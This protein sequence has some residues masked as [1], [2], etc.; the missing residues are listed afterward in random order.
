[1][2]RLRPAK[3]PNDTDRPVWS[4][5]VNAGAV[6]PVSRRGMM[7]SFRW[8]PRDSSPGCMVP[9]CVMV[10]V[11]TSPD[12]GV[13]RTWASR[14]DPPRPLSR[15]RSSRP[16]PVWPAPSTSWRS[17]P[18]PRRLRADRPNPPRPSSSKSLTRPRAT[19]AWSASARSRRA[20]PCCWG[21]PSFDVTAI[22][23]GLAI[24][25]V[26]KSVP[27]AADD[28]LPIRMLH[29][30]VLVSTEGEAGERQ[31]GGGLVIPATASIGKRLAWATVVAI[32]QHVRQIQVG[33][34]ILYDPEDRAEVELQSKGYVLLRERDIHAVAEP[35]VEADPTG[36]SL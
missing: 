21:W 34:R 8:M 3:S 19:Y 1:M 23:V 27:P 26:A 10:P 25:A 18:S 20:R 4:S 7:E 6:W 13:N 22:T 35:R 11:E 14:P 2:I 5:N 17:G 15:P 32:G 16:V 33:D 30:R 24:A 28:R 36:L 9:V 29:D 31:T 12:K